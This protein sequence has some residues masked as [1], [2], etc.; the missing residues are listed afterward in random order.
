[1]GVAVENSSGLC[2]IKLDGSVRVKNA[3][4][5]KAALVKSLDKSDDFEVDLSGVEDIDTTGL[6]ILLALS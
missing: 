3:E 4:E 1:M 5:I 2:R 6:Q